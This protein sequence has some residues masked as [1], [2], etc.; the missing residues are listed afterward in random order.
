MTA[1]RSV[2]RSIGATI[3]LIA[4]VLAVA[5]PSAG[6]AAADPPPRAPVVGPEL[7]VSY[8]VPGTRQSG[9]GPAVASGG[10]ISLAVWNGFM[11]R[12]DR[13]GAVIDPSRVPL[14]GYW[15]DV[16]FGDENFLVV[17]SN[18]DG[19]DSGVRARR[20]SPDGTVLDVI[21][22]HLGG[23]GVGARIS[24]DG[25]NFLVVWFAGDYIFGTRVS[26][27]GVVL[28]P[29][30]V[31]VSAGVL[32]QL[33]IAFDG[34]H[35]LLVWD[36]RDPDL[37]IRGTLLTPD[38][39]PVDPDGFPV[40]PP[41]GIPVRPSVTATGDG[42]FVAWIRWGDVFGSRIDAAGTVLDPA[43]IPIAT[44][45]P[46][47]IPT[48]DV[49]SDGT[50]VLV[51][52]QP[53]APGTDGTIRLSRIGPD[54]T[55]LD[56]AGI[57]VPV[58]NSEAKLSFEGDHYLAVGYHGDDIRGT[59]V[60]VGGAVLDPLGID[61]SIGANAQTVSD[62]AFDGTNTFVV[63]Y[64]N[65]EVAPGLQ[66][67]GGRVGPE[68]QVLDG[69]GIPLSDGDQVSA[70]SVAFDGDNFLVV[71]S[72]MR[73]DR[74]EQAIRAA[75][76]NR[77]GVLLGRF[78]IAVAGPDQRVGEPGVAF[79]GGTYLV[80]WTETTGVDG[81][82]RAARVTP[83]GVVTD[84]DGFL[85]TDHRTAGSD[86]AFGGN[87]FL[88]VWSDAPESGEN[89]DVVGLRVTTAGTVPD[90]EP[91]RISNAPGPEL[92]AA[93]AWNEDRFLVA[94]TQVT[95]LGQ[96]DGWDIYAARVDDAGAVLDPAGI[97]IAT[98]P[99]RKEAPHVAANGP[100]LVTWT[101]RRRGG[102]HQDLLGSR[103]DPDGAVATPE[104]FVIATDE[105]ADDRS[106]TS[107]TPAAGSND[108]SVVYARFLADQPYGATRA[109]LRTVAPK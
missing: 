73:E 19:N 25:T 24:F 27:A 28:E 105:D 70:S 46:D 69:T 12:V 86:A 52:W 14:P 95:D 60:T 103:V 49:A 82:L 26:P 66:L 31:I 68:G 102:P 47:L 41:V 74:G 50:N 107:V 58:L 15:P 43:G 76:V 5:G 22:L 83:G 10:G 61:I 94:W 45:G 64:D 23:Y 1:T 88:V 65:R 56:P 2:G 34:T 72:E 6:V 44:G 18:L 54:G 8:P 80:H 89:L 9:N 79:G 40:A 97:P 13:A 11:A 35:H 20:V 67:Y 87:D 55:V 7:P 77:S 33:D 16:A 63:W 104:G 37:D 4:F 100:F 96:P 109:F 85:L 51:S 93:V 75:R 71:W 101:D 17:W 32:F 30:H 81:D 62:A 36:R 53:S 21:D 92:Q 108:F 91:V 29:A 57:R 106:G 84:P 98:G 3:G 99:G 78:D 38:G 42:F 90:R 39:S 48:P 59:R